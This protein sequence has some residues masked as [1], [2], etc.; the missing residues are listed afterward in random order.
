MTGEIL[1]AA[2]AMS[3]PRPS[4]T[5]WV[6]VCAISLIRCDET[7]TVRPSSASDLSSSRIQ[8]T[9]SGS[10]PLTGSSSTTVCG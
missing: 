4:T 5:S 1:D 9:P 3:L 8:R 2:L 6:A 10:R 7:K